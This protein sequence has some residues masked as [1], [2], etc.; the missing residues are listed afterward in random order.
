[1]VSNALSLSGLVRGIRGQKSAAQVSAYVSAALGDIKSELR[2]TDGFDKANALRK[3]TFLQMMGYDMSWASFPAIETMSSPR[4]AHK[5][6]G[7]LAAT[8]GFA[9]DT[10]VVLL[11]TNLLKKELRSPCGYAA[12]LAVN[13]LSN[14]VT[15]DL[16]QDLL[17]DLVEL[18]RHPSPYVRKKAVLGLFKL[19]VRYP[20]GLRL[21]FDAVRGCLDDPDPSVVSC[22][23]NVVT[24][25]SDKNPR[26]YLVLAPQFFRLLT[27][28]SNN[29]T[30][31]KVVKLLGSLVGEEPRLAR[32][33]LEPLARIVQNT[34]AKSLLYEAVYTITLA[35]PFARKADGSVPKSVPALVRLCSD[36][37]GTFVGEADQNLK[38]LGLVGF[39]SLAASHPRAA[40]EHR[41]PILQCLCDDD[42]TIRTRALELLAGMATRR[43]L[44]ELVTQLLGHVEL[45]GGAYR[46]ALISRVV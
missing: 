17:P 29:W 31:I 32:K 34:Q 10:E 30:L 35:I 23:V 22:A 44:R 28:S 18:V 8:Q 46:D 12:G 1:M 14:I 45:A 6:V 5:R 7:Y 42:V 43:N 2:S 15:A 9:E 36:T 11:T 27:S 40:V 25:L 16:A 19:F 20:Q 4:F 13:C 41:G 21:A 33:L 38:Y 24:E 3:L 26:N 39:V 37:L